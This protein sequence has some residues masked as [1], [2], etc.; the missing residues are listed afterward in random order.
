M[1]RELEELV[2][3]RA[4]DA[5]EYCHLPQECSDAPFQIDHVIAA[6]H[7]GATRS[8][9]LCLACFPCNCFRGTNLA[10]VDPKT[11]KVV[12]LFSPRRHKWS[13]HFRWD[14]ALLV[15]RTA[16]GRATIA[17]LRVNQDYRIA[18]RQQL[19]DEGAFLSE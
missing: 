11:N 7:G 14:R 19:I 17:T 16:N 5:C 6:S 9:N 15:G 10:G 4:N 1:D 3:R 8:G 13:T 2:W 18:R 12:P